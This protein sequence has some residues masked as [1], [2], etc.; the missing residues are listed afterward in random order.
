MP[1]LRLPSL[2]ADMEEG[3]LLEWYVK[4]GDRIE[5]GDIIALLDTEKAEIEME[6]FDSGT[7]DALL[8]EA[9]ET[10][11]VGTPILRLRSPESD[12]ASESPAAPGSTATSESPAPAKPSV[13]S[14]RPEPRQPPLPEKPAAEGQA[15]IAPAPAR[16][17]RVRA[18]PLARR[19]ARERGVDLGELTGSGPGGAITEA[20]VPAAG[21]RAPEPKKDATRASRRR[22]IIAE[23][24]SRSKREIPHYYLATPI[25]IHDTL[26]WLARHNQGHGVDDHILLPALLIKSVARAAGRFPDLNGHWLEDGFHPAEAVHVGMV[27]SLR[28]GGLMVPTFRN[29]D[30]RSVPDLMAELRDIVGRARAGRLRSG[31]LHDATITLTSLGERGAETIFGVIYPPQVA[32]VGFG[33]VHTMAWAEGDLHGS[34]PVVRATLSADHR[35]SDGQQGSRFLDAIARTLRDPGSL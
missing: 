6:A 10:I 30:E 4:P 24:M 17:E 28:S 13:P 12:A 5:Y 21:A 3:T 8:V 29:A 11:P 32:I 26:S 16:T 25:E 35:A 14:K 34:R 33:G 2:G 9:G 27:V 1:E 7:I 31:E 23:A 20:D 22:E 15:A 18:T 19:L